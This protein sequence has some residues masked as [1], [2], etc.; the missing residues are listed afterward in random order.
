MVANRIDPESVHTSEVEVQPEPPAK[1]LTPRSPII[2]KDP[3][4]PK[5]P[6]NWRRLA[7]SKS[8]AN[9]SQLSRQTSGSSLSSSGDR[10]RYTHQSTI[11]LS[12]SG[13]TDL[14]TSTPKY[15]LPY[16]SQPYGDQHRVTSHGSQPYGDQRRVTGHGSQHSTSDGRLMGSAPDHPV[17]ATIRQPA[18]A[19]NAQQRAVEYNGYERDRDMYNDSLYSNNNL[20]RKVSDGATSNPR[21]PNHGD[22][23][24]Q[25]SDGAT[26]NPRTPNH[27]DNLYIVSDGTTS[28]TRTPNHGDNLYKVSEGA[29]SNTRTPNHG[30]NLYKV[31][32]G[33]TSTTRTPN[34]GDNLYTSLPRKSSAPSRP[35]GGGHSNQYPTSRDHYG[36]YM[37]IDAPVWSGSTDR[38][39]YNVGSSQGPNPGA[40]QPDGSDMNSQYNPG[41]VRNLLQSFQMSVH[42]QSLPSGVGHPKQ[43][44]VPPPRRT[45]PLSAGGNMGG[46]GSAFSVPRPQSAVP[47]MTSFSGGQSHSSNSNNNNLI[48]DGEKGD[49]RPGSTPPRPN[50]TGRE[51]PPNKSSVWYEYG[52][53]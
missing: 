9:I 23:L 7:S 34:H 31:S 53:I 4:R 21:T 2:E 13:N 38:D 49:I 28:T 48:S 29:T 50:P 43:P 44:P 1:F 37:S 16:G 33:A 6:K 26:S 25:V 24:Y 10:D 39:S 3:A 52:C 42:N 36:N 20:Q 27:G 18:S 11:N 14:K 46:S 40:G 19:Y 15:A 35:N 22:N 47:N 17:Y 51:G 5:T 12:H 32:D 45:R 30:D 8:E 41:N